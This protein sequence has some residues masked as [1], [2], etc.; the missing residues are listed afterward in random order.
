[1]Q[2]QSNTPH[3]DTNSAASSGEFGDPEPA[4]PP[5]TWAAPLVA[6]ARVRCGQNVYPPSDDT[7]LLLEVLAA[8]A[9]LLCSL[10]PRL[11]LEVGSGSGAVLAGLLDVLRG[12]TGGHPMVTLPLFVAIDKNP[13]ATACTRALLHEHGA[14]QMAI[15]QGCFASGLNLEGKVDVGICNPPYVP[16]EPDEMHGC[17]I[18]VSW[19]GG[20]QGREM[21][22]QL[23]PWI[24]KQL[25]PGGLFYLVCIAENEPDEIMEIIRSHGLNA[26][27]VRREKRGMEELSVLRF[28]RS[29]E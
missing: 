8:D 2:M 19:A 28:Q 18:Q 9:E 26:T 6:D 23:L 16:T 7:F 3:D 11:C 4:C 21:I 12:K 13:D 27:M 29:P 25:S 24:G 14:L 22:N 20:A 10:Q 17:G 1:M 5:P 15:I